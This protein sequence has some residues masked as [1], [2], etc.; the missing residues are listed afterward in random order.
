MPSAQHA[1]LRRWRTSRTRGG[2]RPQERAL[3]FPGDRSEDAAWTALFRGVSIAAPAVLAFRWLC[4]LRVA[5]YSYDWIDNRGR[6]SP[7]TLTPGLEQLAVGQNVMEIFRLESFEEPVHLTLVTPA[8]GRGERLFGRMRCTYWVRPASADRVRLLVKLASRARAG[9]A[10]ALRQGRPRLGRSR[11]DAAPAAE[12]EGAGG[13]ALGSARDGPLAHH[14]PRHLRGP[15]ADRQSVEHRGR[16]PRADGA[17]LGAG[18]TAPGDARES[19]CARRAVGVPVRGRA[20]H[21]LLRHLDPGA[22][23]RRRTDRRAGRLLDVV[24]SALRRR[25]GSAGARRHRLHAARGADA[26]RPRLDRG[27]DRHGAGAHRSRTISRSP[28]ESGSSSRSRGPPFA[29]RAR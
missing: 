24:T 28:R 29:A 22:A 18:S 8:G 14:G 12:P 23:D 11:D 3:A 9:R 27:D 13:I 25:V 10:V 6:Q 20:D 26:E 4:Q 15:A 16:L 19:V 17:A 1:I 7:R 5:P 2:R 21:E